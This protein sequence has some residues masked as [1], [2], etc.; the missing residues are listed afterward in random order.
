MDRWKFTCVGC[1]TKMDVVCNNCE[2][3]LFTGLKQGDYMW[4]ECDHCKYENDQMSHACSFTPAFDSIDKYRP[5]EIH[6]QAT[7]DFNANRDFFFNVGSEKHLNHFL[8]MIIF[9]I[10]LYMIYTYGTVN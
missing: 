7:T 2:S 9:L 4:L 10:F 1:G 6:K 5:E 8:P 3:R